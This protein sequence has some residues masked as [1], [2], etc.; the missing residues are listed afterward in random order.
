M[1]QE[2]SIRGVTPKSARDARFTHTILCLNRPSCHCLEMNLSDS[3]R[4]ADGKRIKVA[5]RFLRERTYGELLEGH[6]RYVIDQSNRRKRRLSRLESERGGSSSAPRIAIPWQTTWM[7]F[8]PTRPGGS[9]PR[10]DYD[11]S[12]WCPRCLS[13]PC[14][15]L[16][17][18]SRPLSGCK[19]ENRSLFDTALGCR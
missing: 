2:K 10:R 19:G 6:R 4:R 5:R 18:T 1:S 8:S 15:N 9:A 17:R 11:R 3:Q 14:R 12:P 13:E 7:W 16:S